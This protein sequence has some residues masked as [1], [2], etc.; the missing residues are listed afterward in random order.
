ML[1]FAANRDDADAFLGSYNEHWWL[2]PNGEGECSTSG[3]A[4]FRVT[5]VTNLNSFVHP[6]V[7]TGGLLRSING[8]APWLGT[9]AAADPF[10]FRPQTQTF[11]WAR[12]I[13]T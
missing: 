8:I 7:T 5:N 3:T 9:L 1:G 11:Q 6:E 10:A 12:Q 13:R 4:Y 2:I